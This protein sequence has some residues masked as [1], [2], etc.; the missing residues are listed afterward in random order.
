MPLAPE[1][2]AIEGAQELYDWF[3][4]WPSFHD[5]EVV[6][7]HLNRVGPSSLVVH[8]WEMTSQVDDHNYF[9]LAKHVVVEFVL[10]EVS[11]L[12]LGGFSSQNVVFA[13][14]IKKLDE[15]FRLRL[16]PCYGL[17]GTIEAKTVRIHLTPG[18]AI[19]SA[20]GKNIDLRPL[21][22]GAESCNAILGDWPTTKSGCVVN[23][24]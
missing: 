3:G 10:I 14:D 2:E 8:T 23:S 20:T 21:K 19:R 4:H 17:A 16:A 12:E 13:L 7:L 22:C 24:P 6:S 15:G 5:A 9:I 18:K 11:E 1:L